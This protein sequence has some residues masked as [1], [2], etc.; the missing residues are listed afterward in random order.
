MALAVTRRQ[1]KLTAME[2]FGP[3]CSIALFV[4]TIIK[5]PIWGMSFLKN[6]VPSL[7]HNFREFLLSTISIL[8]ARSVQAL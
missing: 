4:G 7:Q 5:T 2:D 8:A 3:T 6:C 1:N